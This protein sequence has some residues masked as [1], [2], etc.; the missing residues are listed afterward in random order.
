MKFRILSYVSFASFVAAGPAWGQA[1]AS[2]PGVDVAVG[3]QGLPSSRP[4]KD[5]G[6]VQLS[7]QTLLHAGVGAEMGYDSNVFYEENDVRG[8]AILRVVPFLEL[9]NATRTG[10]APSGVYFDV[11]AALTYREYLSSDPLIKQQRAFM[12]GAYGNLEIGKLQSVSFGLTEA[13]NRTEDPPYLRVANL[14]PIIRD[15]NQASAAVRWAPGGGRL[16]G[17][18]RYTNTLDVFET[19]NLRIA[20]SMGHLLTLDTSWKWLPKTALVL[21]VS[22]GY[23]AYLNKDANGNSKPT[24]FPFHALAGVRGLITAKL[25]LNLLAGYANGFYDTVHQ[26][27]SGFRGNISVGGDLTYHPTILT[28]IVLGYRHDFENAVLGDFYYLDSVYLN[29][30]QA[31]AGR[32]GFGFS[33]RYDSRSFQNVPVTGGDVIN[34]HDNYWQVG[35]NLDYHIRDWTYAG[36]AYTFMSNSSA[37]NP[38]APQDPGRVNYTKHLIFARLGVTY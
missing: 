18:I 4:P 19:D 12:P 28:S 16:A 5:Q 24:S 23:I 2:G 29:V 11:G 6:G 13:F 27:T 38:M 1:S 20:N 34:R 3:Y 15:V 17:V 31:I 33:A 14:E 30:G 8:S 37:Y 21:Q 7:D 25:S 22:Q 10:D 36:V 26:G 9:T 32:L 35:T